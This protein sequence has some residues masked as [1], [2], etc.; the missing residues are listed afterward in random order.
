LWNSIPVPPAV[1][2]ILGPELCDILPC[3]MLTVVI[4]PY[5]WQMAEFED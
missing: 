4:L 2:A 3:V 5:N 1:I